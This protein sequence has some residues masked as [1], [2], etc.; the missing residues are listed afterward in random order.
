MK[1]TIVKYL[2]CLGFL[3][4]MQASNSSIEGTITDYRSSDPLMG[5]NI[6]LD[7]TML[8]AAS[9]ENGYYIIKNIPIGTYT[10]R[11]MFIGYEAYEK[12]V[13]IEA[14]EKYV[15]DIDLKE[16]AIEIQE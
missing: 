11:A 8:G 4:L 7:G 13:K 3:T 6:M 5:A 15:V 14:D 9:D 12:E 16:S 2:F 1:V 10:L